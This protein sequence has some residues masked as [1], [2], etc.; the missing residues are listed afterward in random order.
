MSFPSSPRPSISPWGNILQADQ[1]APGIWSVICQNHGGILLSD[2]RQAAMPD[3]LKLD[4]AVYEEDCDWSL[5]VI[6]FEAELAGAKTFTAG[7]LQLA[8]DT[9]KCWHP[10]RY[11]KHT[12]STVA[13]NT[14]HVLKTRRAYLDAIGEY[15]TTSAWGD[16][17]EWVPKGKTGVLAR[18][19][20]SVNHLGRPTYAEDEIC[21]LIDKD[22]Y[23]ARGD[24]TILRDTPHEVI[25]MPEA[26]R[27]KRIG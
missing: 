19:V 18:K 27:P 14:S 12:G 2:L 3:P 4:E 20:L 9:A 24:V 1:I 23:S 22:I 16:W 6:A 21:A 26:I 17:A 15:C 5:P 7:F 25:P 8:H 13:E 10:E 11:T